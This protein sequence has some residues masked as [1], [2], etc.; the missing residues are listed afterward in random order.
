MNLENLG[1]V[2]IQGIL[3]GGLYALLALGLSL[4]FGVMKLIN[5]AHGDLMLLSAYLAFAI[6]THIKVDPV[7]TLIIGLPV[8]FVIGYG[9][10]KFL[11]NRAFKISMEAPLIITFG[12]SIILQNVYQIIWTP[13]ARGLS[14]S[15]SLASLIFGAIRIPM[16]Y[17]LDFLVALVIMFALHQFMKRTYIGQAITAASQDR[18]TA[19]LMGINVNRVYAFAFAIAMLLAAIAGIFLGVTFPFTPQSGVSFLIIAF[20]V[21]VLGGLGS[22]MGT[23]IGGLVMGLAQTLGGQYI[24]AGAQLLVAYLIIFIML[25]LRPQGIFGR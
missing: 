12:I 21:V 7:L 25:G 6:I 10:Q 17:L 19:E 18:S 5:L 2:I 15:Y 23:F 8:L 9:I 24:S 3:L 13:Q 20:G 11:L 22:I 16:I 14:T 4:V 1:N